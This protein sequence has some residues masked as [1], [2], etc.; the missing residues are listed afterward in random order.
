MKLLKKKRYQSEAC[1]LKLF[2][3]GL[4]ERKNTPERASL[5]E[6]HW[7]TAEQKEH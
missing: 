6:E 3:K 2:F 1:R 7:D 4:G 5:S